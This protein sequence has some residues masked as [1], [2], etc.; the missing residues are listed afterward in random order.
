M[1]LQLIIR[2]PSHAAIQAQLG[3]F[4]EAAEIFALP[5]GEFGLSIPTKVLEVAGEGTVR[6][7]L[8]SLTVYDLY[9]GRWIDA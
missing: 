1:A 2:A 3:E 8:V 7:A 9:E 6:K 4:A 5:D